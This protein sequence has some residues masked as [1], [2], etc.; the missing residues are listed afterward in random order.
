VPPQKKKKSWSQVAAAAAPATGPATSTS[1]SNPP[2]KTFPREDREVVIPA[3]A[4]EAATNITSCLPR[5]HA[6][7]T[8]DLAK[9]GKRTALP[10]QLCLS[11]KGAIVITTAPKVPPSSINENLEA[12]LPQICQISGTTCTQIV[13]RKAAISFLIHA[14]PVPGQRT[15]QTQDQHEE[16]FL[17][18]LINQI[19]ANTACPPT[20][21]KFLR[22][23]EHRDTSKSQGSYVA[24]VASFPTEPTFAITGMNPAEKTN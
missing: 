10:I 17:N 22:N 24:I 7:L 19:E 12:L 4:A 6:I 16:E 13:S 11:K 21:V 15:T 1:P 23:R 9:C 20:E 14:V 2:T 5:L 8:E 18:S 3:V